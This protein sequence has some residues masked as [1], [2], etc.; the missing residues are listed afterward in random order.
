MSASQL[1]QKQY[2]NKRRKSLEFKV[3]DMVII[4]VSPC[5]GIIRFG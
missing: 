2:E 4:K 5:K 1:R 3:D